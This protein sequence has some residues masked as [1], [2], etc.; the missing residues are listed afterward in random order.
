VSRRFVRSLPNVEERPGTVIVC[1]DS[2]ELRALLVSRLAR[3]LGLEVVADVS[4]GEAA[5]EAVLRLRPDALLLDLMLDDTDPN[6]M[7]Q[8]LAVIDGRPLVIVFSGLAP[9][10]LERESRAVVDVH[11]DKTTP[12]GTVAEIV[13]QTIATHR[14]GERL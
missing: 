3:E 13:L 8:A 9:G 2:T 11:V 4:D 6:E 7:L 12:L 10:A 1:E 5:L 14:T